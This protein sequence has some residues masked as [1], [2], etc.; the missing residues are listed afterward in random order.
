MGIIASV[1]ISKT[2]VRVERWKGHIVM[3]WLVIRKHDVCYVCVRATDGKD[4][5]RE[6]GVQGYFG[7]DDGIGGA[8]GDVVNCRI[9][10]CTC[11]S[12]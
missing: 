1:E 11:W 12:R 4:G 6:R 2:V 5:G 8:G 7:E 10:Q 3:V 9:L